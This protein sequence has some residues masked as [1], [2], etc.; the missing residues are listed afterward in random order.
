MHLSNLQEPKLLLAKLPTLDQWERQNYGDDAAWYC[1]ILCLVLFD[2]AWY[3]FM[4]LGINFDFTLWFYAWNYLMLVNEDKTCRGRSTSIVGM[5]GRGN[6]PN[7]RLGG[8]GIAPTVGMGRQKNKQP[9]K[10]NLTYIFCVCKCNTCWVS[11]YLSV[12]KVKITCKEGKALKA[13][14]LTL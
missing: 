11:G 4:M 14:A 8:I 13:M 7:A 5:R 1:L 12:P 9:A 6:A 10:C 2:V 3:Y